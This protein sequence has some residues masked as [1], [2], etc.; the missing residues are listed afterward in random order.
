MKEAW[1]REV[2]EPCNGDK[3]CLWWPGE[4]GERSVP[5]PPPTFSSKVIGDTSVDRVWMGPN[6]P[7]DDGLTGDTGDRSKPLKPRL[8]SFSKLPRM[9]AP[10]LIWLSLRPYGLVWVTI[11]GRATLPD[12]GGPPM[13]SKGSRLNLFDDRNDGASVPAFVSSS[14]C[15]TLSD[16]SDI[17][18][19]C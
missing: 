8:K 13:G 4:V 3:L 19:R 11:V 9:R 7:L 1:L 6:A 12:L 18:S 2:V 14:D 5:G 15:S 10:A 16:P 17:L